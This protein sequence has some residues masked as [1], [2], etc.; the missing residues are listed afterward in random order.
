MLNAILSP[1]HFDY[2]FLWETLLYILNSTDDFKYFAALKTNLFQISTCQI[3]ILSH[4]HSILVFFTPGIP[5]TS[6]VILIVFMRILTLTFSQKL[7]GDQE[8]DHVLLDVHVF[9][10]SPCVLQHAWLFKKNVISSDE[11]K[12]RET[13]CM[14]KNINNC[15]CSNNIA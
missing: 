7:H 5:L 2:F 4:A 9:L 6:S 13:K 8:L 1:F 3:F 11:D 10:L 12:Q 14:N 15:S